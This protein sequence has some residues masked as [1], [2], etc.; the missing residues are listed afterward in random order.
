M[1]IYINREKMSVSSSSSSSAA[2]ALHEKNRCELMRKVE[3]VVEPAY[4]IH[5]CG[6]TSKE[7]QS[8]VNDY[9]KLFNETT[10]NVLI[11]A[12]LPYN[13]K[14]VE[15]RSPLM[16]D[17]IGIPRQKVIIHTAPGKPKPHMTGSS[18]NWKIMLGLSDLNDWFDQMGI[19]RSIMHRFK[20][21]SKQNTFPTPSVITMSYLPGTK[22][23]PA[24]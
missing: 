19:S 12:Y 13:F 22:S 24:V 16:C 15:D 17:W 21:L 14:G 18:L 4:I 10:D 7:L 3:A 5:F 2:W 20:P 1:P 23:L 8:Q 6:D 11:L 9:H